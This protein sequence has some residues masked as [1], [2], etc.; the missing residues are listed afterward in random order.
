MDPVRV[1]ELGPVVGLLDKLGQPVGGG[2]T[3]L[4]EAL[5]EDSVPRER[6][7]HAGVEVGLWAVCEGEWVVLWFFRCQLVL[8]P[9]ENF[10]LR[11]DSIQAQ[12]VL[13]RGQLGPKAL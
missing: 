2:D 3:G 8:L 9:T 4:Y 1:G 5:R 11:L 7:H 12:W 13:A 10:G 6:L